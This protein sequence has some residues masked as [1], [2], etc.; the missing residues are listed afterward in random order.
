MKL[1]STVWQVKD[2]YFYNAINR[3]K[4]LAY[5]IISELQYMYCFY[6]FLQHVSSWWARHLVPG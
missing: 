6:S 2:F 4:T 1:S 5:E 3:H